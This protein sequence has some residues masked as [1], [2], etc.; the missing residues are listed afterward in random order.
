M[1]YTLAIIL[2]MTQRE[3]IFL[4]KQIQFEEVDNIPKDYP[5]AENTKKIQQDAY[6]RLVNAYYF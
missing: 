5:M 2:D 3:A 1:G 4:L 6:R